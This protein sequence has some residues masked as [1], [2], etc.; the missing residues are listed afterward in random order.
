MPEPPL[1]TSIHFRTLASI[2]ER[3]YA[4][5]VA[6]LAATL[7]RSGEEISAGL[8]EL[9]DQHGIVLQPDS[10][11]IW[12]AHPF[13]LMPTGITL[14]RGES[15]WWSNCIWCGLGAAHLLGG[16]VDLTMPI[17]GE[18]ELATL[19]FRDGELLDPD[20][21][22]HFAVPMADAWRNVVYTCAMMCLFRKPADVLTWCERHRLPLGDIRPLSRVWPFA[23]EWYGRHLDRDWRKW[24]AAEAAG[25]FARHGLDGPI[26]N[27]GDVSERF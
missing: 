15:V 13:A 27:L 26:W 25:I 8:R 18:D 20:Y 2:V 23:K 24:T 3:G 4:P 12:I 19:R 7:D 9:S 6:E 11:E 10:D 22:A 17:G 5:D 1:S 14:R 16:D 21:V